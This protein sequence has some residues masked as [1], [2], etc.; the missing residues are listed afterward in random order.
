M[1]HST[2]NRMSA[3]HVRT[4]PTRLEKN[5]SFE[6]LEDRRLLAVTTFDYDTA[7]VNIAYEAG[8]SFV[9]VGNNGTRLTVNGAFVQHSQSS[10]TKYIELGQIESLRI[11]GSNTGD[12]QLP[13]SG[14]PGLIFSDTFNSLN[15]PL[16]SGLTVTGVDE[17]Q[18]TG[19]FEVGGSISAAM[20]SPTSLVTQTPGSTLIVRGKTHMTLPGGMVFLNQPANDFGEA[21][22]LEIGPSTG[23][24]H[25]TDANALVLSFVEVAG[26]LRLNAPVIADVV[27]ASIE[28]NDILFLKG[29]NI[30]LGDNADLVA[31]KI[32]V[33]ADGFAEIR[34]KSDM[35]L[36]GASFADEARLRSQGMIQDAGNA[37]LDVAGH[38]LLDARGGIRL[39]D[40]DSSVFNAGT[41]FVA[42]SG[43]VQIQENSDMVLTGVKV[44]SGNVTLG[45]TGSMTDVA[46]ARIQVSGDLNLSASSIALGNSPTDFFKA[47][48]VQVQSAGPV[49][50]YSNGDMT[51]HGSNSALD[52]TLH[53]GGGHLGNA[54]GTAFNATNQTTLSG[55]SV[56]I[57]LDG[58]FA[59]RFLTLQS[60]G[61]VTVRES[62]SMLLVGNSSANSFRLSSFSEIR[63]ANNARVITTHR[64]DLA[65][66]SVTMGSATGDYVEFRSLRFTT[67]GG[68]SLAA[69][70]DI[71]VVLSNQSDTLSLSSTGSIYD[72][73]GSSIAISGATV[74]AGVNIV[75]GDD[76]TECFVANPAN[77]VVNASGVASITYC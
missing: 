70:T 41:L 2:G 9:T 54:P 62:D 45:S 17:M 44:D 58:S 26:T 37:R 40:F 1:K 39:G 76:P 67:T 36:I 75:L 30:I 38:L 8:D 29:T 73:P 55:N 71:L 5:C 15:A 21:L 72:Q 63:N 32:N 12:S 61:N 59:T 51:M 35:L 23:E 52:L 24:S 43:N 46:D 64:L 68:M 18:F 48:R 77:V 47:G 49:L 16:L 42:A 66:A 19:F 7:T 57:G 31:A 13:S 10:L 22:H 4:S 53:A 34:M 27:G 69:D 25:I 60:P 14:I 33:K 56:T 20:A 65:A 6:R 28:V 3:S 11:I 74:L 50:I